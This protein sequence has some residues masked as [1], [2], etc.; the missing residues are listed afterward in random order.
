[1]S[2]KPLISFVLIAYKQERYIREAVLG[3]LAQTYSP[4]EIILSDDCSPDR[5]FQ[6]MQEV[7]GEYSGP[8]EVRLRQNPVNSGLARH[9]NAALGEARGEIFVIGAGDDVS[10]PERTENLFRIYEAGGSNV[11]AVFSNALVVDE[12]GKPGSPWFEP[13]WSPTFNDDPFVISFSHTPMVLGA[14]NSIRKEVWTNF[15]TFD[16]DIQQEDVVLALRSRLLGTLR[17][18][19]ECLVNY[20]RHDANLFCATT[21]TITSGTEKSLLNRHALARQQKTDLKRALDLGAISRPAYLYYRAA[22]LHTRTMVVLGSAEGALLKPLTFPAL[23]IGK[24]IRRID[25]ILK[26]T[27]VKR[28]AIDHAA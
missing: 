9:V 28:R 21:L 16:P 3:A 13:T 6:F 7:A 23:F 8:H 5:T 15:P 14:T 18:S 4:L 22:I 2:S 27:F 20:R 24:V 1:M 10:L 19:Q 25:R 17:Y 26:R 11:A 12:T